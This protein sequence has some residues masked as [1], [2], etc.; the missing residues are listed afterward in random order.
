MAI[1]IKAFKKEYK[2]NDYSIEKYQDQLKSYQH[3]RQHIEKLLFESRL[4]CGMLL[5]RGDHLRKQFL[6][7]V[8]ELN[9]VL[10]SCIKK[11]MVQTNALIEA[12]V[13]GVLKV[14]NKEPLRD[15]EE[16]SEVQ[17]FIDNLPKK[18]L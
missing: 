15:I 9:K 8:E 18:Q 3:A 11:K 6:A 14:I 10:F 7:K 4:Q 16:V 17:A 2:N 13:E 1:D 5:I 12:E